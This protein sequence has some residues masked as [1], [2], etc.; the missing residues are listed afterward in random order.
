MEERQQII[1]N[2]LEICD[3]NGNKIDINN[4][5]IEFSCN[6]YSSKKNSIYHIL[7]N[8]VHLSK[9]N[10]YSIKYKCITC[11][12]IN[13]VGTTQFLRKVNKCSYRCYVCC[14]K[15][16]MKRT[17][18]SLMMKN[19]MYDKEENSKKNS[20]IDYREYSEKIFN[21]YDDDFKEKY[22]EYHLTKEDYKRI[23]KNIL[24]FQNGKY[25]INDN[26]EYCPIYK[27]N[28]Q[29]LFT[30][31]FYDKTNDILFR[32][33][34]PI[35]K[36]SNCEITWRAKKIE[37][38]K[39]CHK[40]LCNNCTLCNKTFKIRNTKNIIN[41]VI[42]FQ[43]QLELKFIQWCS[44]NNIVVKNGPYIPYMIDGVKKIYRVDFQ[45]QDILIEIKD[46]HIWHREQVNSGKWNK[47]EHAVF[48]E[49]EKGNYKS[50]HL[51]MPKNWIKS[52]NNILTLIK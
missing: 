21:E 23:S 51:I 50:Y 29:M 47:K 43:S 6:K 14:N 12:N 3:E 31:M 39:N 7:L 16:E 11:D 19:N 49:I 1:N 52:L 37:R 8:D 20:Y 34:Q 28:N 15:E 9:R 45:I 33:N 44:N 48:Q 26:I 17:N 32:P 46:N 40:I 25:L 13:N 5:K 42:T 30:C 36:C 18:H 24:S 2:I 35:M 10:K 41:E 27:T 4:I 22:F 38:F